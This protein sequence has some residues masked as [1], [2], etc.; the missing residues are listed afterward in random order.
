MT[1]PP[2][3]P[4]FVAA[5]AE[6][7]QELTIPEVAQTVIVTRTSMK[8][9]SMPEGEDLETLRSIKIHPCYSFISA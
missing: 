4:A 8:S 9:S 1:L 6:L 7:K 5:A 2:G 3:V